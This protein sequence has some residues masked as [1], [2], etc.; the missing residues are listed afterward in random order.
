MQNVLKATTT[1]VTVR[2]CV[3]NVT[4]WLPQ[5]VVKP[6]ENV[7]L[8]GVNQLGRESIVHK[9]NNTGSLFHV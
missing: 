3:I 4:V 9:V 8:V 1:V 6:Q 5:S 7:E 2:S